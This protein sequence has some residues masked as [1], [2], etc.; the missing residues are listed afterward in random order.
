MMWTA[1][2][3]CLAGVGAVYGLC[4]LSGTLARQQERLRHVQQERKENEQM[5]EIMRRVGRINDA[6]LPKFLRAE[7]DKK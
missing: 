3:L 1:L 2:M 4:R 7:A 6:D 5:D